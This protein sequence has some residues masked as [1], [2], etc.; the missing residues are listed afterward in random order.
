M[1]NLPQDYTDCKSLYEKFRYFSAKIRIFPSS[2][3]GINSSRLRRKNVSGGKN[4]NKSMFYLN[5]F[6]K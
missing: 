2:R 5:N 4:L 1:G 6:N 3:I